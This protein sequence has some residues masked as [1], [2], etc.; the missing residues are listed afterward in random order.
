MLT[1]NVRRVNHHNQNN[2]DEKMA[3]HPANK[4]SNPTNDGS[5]SAAGQP[6]SAR[7]LALPARRTIPPILQGAAAPSPLSTAA[8][9]LVLGP[10]LRFQV[11]RQGAWVS[12]LNRRVLL[13]F[14]IVLS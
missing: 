8:A 7:P 4:E 3:I 5:V 13:L 12:A 14:R 1:L 10:V 11:R 9:L 2:V 6:E